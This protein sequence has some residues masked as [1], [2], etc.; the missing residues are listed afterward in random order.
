MY[1]DLKLVIRSKGLRKLLADK[2]YGFHWR[3]YNSEEKNRTHSPHFESTPEFRYHSARNENPV[4]NSPP[5]RN[6]A[7]TDENREDVFHLNQNKNKLRDRSQYNDQ[8]TFKDFQDKEDMIKFT[9]GIDEDFKRLEV[10]S[11]PSGKNIDQNM[12]YFQNNFKRP[13]MKEKSSQTLPPEKEEK[14]QFNKSRN[15]DQ[16]EKERIASRWNDRFTNQINTNEDI[17]SSEKTEIYAKRANPLEQKIG[18]INTIPVSSR[19][20]SLQYIHNELSKTPN[21]PV[22]TQGEEYSTSKGTQWEERV[23]CQKHPGYMVSF[24]CLQDKCGE[25][26]C[27]TCKNEHQRRKHEGNY[28]TLQNFKKNIS[29]V[30]NEACESLIESNYNIQ[31]LQAGMDA[32]EKHYI[33]MGE[34]I[35]KLE[36]NVL[37]NVREYFETMRQEFEKMVILDVKRVRESLNDLHMT[38]DNMVN[39]LKKDIFCLS[40]RESPQK[41]LGVISKIV[42]ESYMGSSEDFQTTIHEVQEKVH[43]FLDHQRKVSKKPRI[44]I[45]VD[46]DLY[47]SIID[48]LTKKIQLIKSSASKFQP[49]QITER[50]RTLTKNSE[51]MR[52]SEKIKENKLKEHIYN[53]PEER[54]SEP[55]EGK[56]SYRTSYESARSNHKIEEMKRRALTPDLDFPKSQNDIGINKPRSYTS[57]PFKSSE[58]KINTNT[59]T[60]S[61][62][63]EY[64]REERHDIKPHLIEQ[65]SREIDAK[66]MKFLVDHISKVYRSET[67]KVF[68]YSF[69][70]DLFKSSSSIDLNNLRKKRL[71]L[72]N[73]REHM[74]MRG[75]ER[76]VFTA[77]D[78]V[79]F[80]LNV[81]TI[82][83]TLIEVRKIPKMIILYD[84]FG[85]FVNKSGENLIEKFFEVIKYEYRMRLNQDVEINMWSRRVSKEPILF[86]KNLNDTGILVLE[87]VVN[88]YQNK[89][90]MKG[91]VS[92]DVIKR[93][94]RNVEQ[95]FRAFESN[96]S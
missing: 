96:N 64:N 17:D 69:F 40:S 68:D 78:K 5:T 11:S 9:K 71:Y 32:R 73:V 42:K 76:C 34:N 16:L 66:A 82:G 20:N 13:E 54:L 53:K 47:A 59:R 67:V 58:K 18:S 14:P 29:G 91:K 38:V 26:L 84:F 24:I 22:L 51:N 19:E 88:A 75:K 81:E 95:I 92:M 25:L 49:S 12:K 87:M 70:E 57:E 48:F 4:Y 6:P 41:P 90:I 62:E 7:K 52:E 46:Q 44:L 2:F 30:L 83:W 93:M 33:E 43:H 63:E 55:R 45:K 79:L 74:N 8:I 56:E 10:K 86:S 35:S 61:D 15:G 23:M 80:L 85:K 37:N 60:K 21:K 72:E 94:R 65:E 1:E 31:Q 3:G 27:Q 39:K 28:E 36:E 89:D 50:G 77:Y